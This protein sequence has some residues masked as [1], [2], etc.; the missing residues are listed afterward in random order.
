MVVSRIFALSIDPNNP[1][2]IYVSTENGIY[3]RT[4]GGSTWLSV[5]NGL[6]SGS[7]YMSSINI[8]RSNSS[9]IYLAPWVNGEIYSTLDAGAIWFALAAGAAALVLGLVF[10]R[11]RPR[12]RYGLGAVA[13]ALF[14]EMQSGL[15]LV[16]GRSGACAGSS[17]CITIS[18]HCPTRNIW[19]ATMMN[20]MMVLMNEP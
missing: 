8:N 19:T 15:F 3:E 12:E 9:S 16:L 5:V 11:D 6:A 10:A 7:N 14:G 20:S 13:A 1:N 17:P 2:N 18:N 4:D